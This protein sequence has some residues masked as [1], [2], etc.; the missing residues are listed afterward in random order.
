M[1]MRFLLSVVAFALLSMAC[2]LLNQLPG[3]GDSTRDISTE[4]PD[5][6]LDEDRVVEMVEGG[7]TWTLFDLINEDDQG[8][9]LEPGTQRY[10]VDIQPDDLIDL[11]TGWCA[12][13]TATM[14]DNE[15]HITGSITVNDYV[16]P[17]DDLVAFS[18][19]VGPGESSDYPDGLSCYSW[20]IVATNWP[21]GTHRVVE[22][23]TLDSDLNDGYSD[24]EAGTYSI[25]YTI[26]VSE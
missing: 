10:T 22:S 2:G 14:E 19:E 15:E 26:T 23:W 3:V 13:D 7:E 25:E 8:E 24:Y 17:D 9:M 12:K 21:V 1:S 5:F 20:D 18:S 16:V 6:E 4:L 11:S